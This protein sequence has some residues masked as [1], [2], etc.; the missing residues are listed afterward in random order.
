MHGENETE[1]PK[2]SDR[3][4]LGK[5]DTESISN[6][7]STPNSNRRLIP[8][9]TPTAIYIPANDSNTGFIRKK[10]HE[11]YMTPYIAEYDFDQIIDRASIICAKAY[12]KVKNHKM[13]AHPIYRILL[14]TSFFFAAIFLL[15]VMVDGE[16]RFWIW[17]IFLWFSLLFAL[18]VLFMT[19]I[20]T[21]PK[22]L[23]FK[24]IAENNLAKFC[25]ELN[26]NTYAVKGMAWGIGPNYDYIRLTL[27]K[28]GT[29]NIFTE[30]IYIHI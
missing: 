30:V 22:K 25:I 24:Q 21:P 14:M 7:P 12:N 26:D 23:D 4:L 9:N 2:E 19:F 10:Y 15:G 16:K 13:G 1:R 11:E 8:N 6:R 20:S 17:C 5:K 29:D 28:G 18:I 3:E 27:P